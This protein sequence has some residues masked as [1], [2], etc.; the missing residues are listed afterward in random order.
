MG[1]DSLIY[2]V[3][4]LLLVF[5]LFRERGLRYRI[6][7]GSV[8]RVSRSSFYKELNKSWDDQVK[9]A[10]K[11]SGQKCS[12]TM[13]RKNNQQLIEEISRRRK[14]EN[15][16]QVPYSKIPTHVRK[17]NPDCPIHMWDDL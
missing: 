2:I 11:S 8:N 1:I 17:H 3:I 12:C 4:I 9:Q 14:S 7:N 13:V 16:A 10:V 6:Q 5:S 15:A